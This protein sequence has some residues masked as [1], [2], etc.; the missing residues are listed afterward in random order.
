MS[1][2]V[3]NLICVRNQ[4]VSKAMLVLLKLVLY[5]LFPTTFFYDEAWTFLNGLCRS[6]YRR[7]GCSQPSLE[8]GC[9]AQGTCFWDSVIHVWSGASAG[10][11][12]SPRMRDW[13]LLNLSIFFCWSY[14]GK[15]SA[16]ISTSKILQGRIL[17][18]DLTRA[19]NVAGCKS[20]HGVERCQFQCSTGSSC[21]TR[22]RPICCKVP[23]SVPLLFLW[24]ESV[25]KFLLTMS[26]FLFLH[27]GTYSISE[28]APDNH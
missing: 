14:P 25:T 1:K 26:T 19:D 8:A 5:A 9:C 27:L 24:H 11:M 17:A 15:Q 22:S 3:V 10:N 23:H 4:E 18:G 7:S 28:P 20:Q 13:C 16:R 12:S 6:E 2:F 21:C